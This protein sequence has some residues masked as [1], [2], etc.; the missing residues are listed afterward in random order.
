MN[1]Y[2]YINMAYLNEMSSGDNDFVIGMLIDWKGMLPEYLADLSAA[3]DNKNKEEIRFSSHKL[4]SSFQIIGAIDLAKICIEIEE[5][6]RIN[7]DIDEIENSFN[8]IIPIYNQVL[9]EVNTALQLL[10]N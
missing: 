9:I 10:N 5:L 1:K 7:A 6:A 8:K 2:K 4:Q 3:M